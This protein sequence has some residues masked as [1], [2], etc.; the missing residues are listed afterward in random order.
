ML[1]V[2]VIYNRVKYR[3][4]YL[5]SNDT[6]VI[7]DFTG[8]NINLDKKSWYVVLRCYVPEVIVVDFAKSQSE[9]CRII[10]MNHL[11]GPYN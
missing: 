1:R 9:Q 8:K 6:R 2:H 7:T 4:T 10:D 3:Y 11:I 5:R